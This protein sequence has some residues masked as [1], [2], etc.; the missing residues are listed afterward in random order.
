MRHSHIDRQPLGDVAGTLTALFAAVPNVAFRY[1]HQ[2]DDRVF[3]VE[4][5]KL[6]EELDGVSLSHPAIAQWLRAHVQAGLR[7]IG[8][9][10]A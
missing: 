3:E 6:K 4:S 1:R 5:E 10:Q 8:A 2:V 9:E 7:G